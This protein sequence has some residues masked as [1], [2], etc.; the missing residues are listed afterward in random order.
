MADAFKIAILGSGPAGLSAA[1][2]A[3]KLGLSYV[4][5]EKTE[6]LSNTIFRYQRG[7][8]IMAT[9]N[10]LVLR[11]D[12]SFTAGSR[13]FLLETWNQQTESLRHQCALWRGSENTDR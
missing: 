12:C 5:L 8:H 7:K 10:Q 2:H 11:S 13:E 1:S 3:A 4:L 9:P 6:Q